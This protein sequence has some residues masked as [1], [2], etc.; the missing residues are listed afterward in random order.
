MVGGQSTGTTG[1]VT[2]G[3]E[4]TSGNDVKRNGID[5]ALWELH[6][7]LIAVAKKRKDKDQ[8]RIA[9]RSA[10]MHALARKLY[11]QSERTRK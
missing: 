4:T 8:A 6:L 3:M 5:G 1:T 9:R 7:H 11:P 2:S 10:D